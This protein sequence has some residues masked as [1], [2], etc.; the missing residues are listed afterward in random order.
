M[1][2]LFSD[3]T[4]PALA[5][6]T[7]TGFQGAPVAKFVT[8]ASLFGHIALHVP[9]FAST[10][11][12]ILFC[13]LPRLFDKGDIWR[14]FTSKLIFFDTKDTIF[15]LILLYQF[16]VFERRFGSR[17]FS[18]H[19]LATTFL[20]GLFE[21]VLTHLFLSSTWDSGKPVL[22]APNSS[23]AFQQPGL[24][25]IGRPF[26]AILPLFV[27]YFCDIPNL[28]GSTFGGISVSSKSMFYIMG[29]Q[30]AFSSTQNTIVF[31]AAILA[32][33]FVRKNVLWIQN[34][35][36]VPSLV[37]SVTDKLL[38]WLVRSTS[39][40]SSGVSELLGAT[41]EIQRAQQ[42]ELMEQRIIRQQQAMFDDERRQRGG[43]PMGA[44]GG[45][46]GRVNRVGQ[47]FQEQLVN[48]QG[49]FPPLPQA[50]GGGGP[51]FRGGGQRRGQP[52]AAGNPAAAAN[53]G[54]AAAVQ[55]PSA[56]NVQLLIDM[57]FSRERV[58]RALRQS[59]DDVESAT[60][61]L[62]HGSPDDL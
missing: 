33:I 57:G 53:E 4:G 22:L 18:S 61:I 30:V 29:A 10:T 16:R 20:T 52:G 59:G 40:T 11:K 26:G 35:F 48:N 44:G 58:M 36:K 51:F 55:E 27:D 37:A 49:F 32:G 38:G 5:Q 45:A 6:T 15:C 62:L 13:H 56:E 17:K 21:V 7:T 24:L 42:V 28:S 2:D 19:L 23:A 41:L 43:Q 34:W 54:G 46:R 31:V 9:M 3:A 39:V 14:L 8:G 25:A 47:G 12:N 60:A 50:A 1:A